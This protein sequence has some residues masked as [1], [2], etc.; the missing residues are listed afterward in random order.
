M[1]QEEVKKLGITIG[2]TTHPL[3]I[4][5]FNDYN[6]HNDRPLSMAC[7]SCWRKVLEYQEK[8]LLK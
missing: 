4:A 3:W 5:A 1:T 6:K 7:V 8:K 2:D